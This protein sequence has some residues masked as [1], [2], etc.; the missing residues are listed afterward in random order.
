MDYTGKEFKIL[1]VYGTAYNIPYLP[2]TV[3]LTCYSFFS[4]IFQNSEISFLTA[5]IV[6]YY[7]QF[8]NHIH[9]PMTLEVFSW[10]FKRVA[11]L[12]VSRQNKKQ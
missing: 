6:V 4:F 3:G 12:E 10:L 5:I 1:C 11:I 8:T 2:S 9:K 7:L